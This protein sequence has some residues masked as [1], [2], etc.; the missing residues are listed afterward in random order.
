MLRGQDENNMSDGWKRQFFTIYFGQAFS[1]LGSSAVSFAII[2]WLT[3]QTESAV[4]LSISTLTTVIPGLI[5]S[6][7]AGVIVDRYSRKNIIIIADGMIALT[8]II[9]AFGFMFF[10]TPPLWFILMIL[11]LRSIGNCFHSP[12]MHAAIP[13]LVPSEKLTQVGGWIS[14]VSSLSN[15]IGPILGAFLVN[16]ISI[17]GAMGVDVAGAVIAI[18]CLLRVTIPKTPSHNLEG[19]FFQDFKQGTNAIRNNKALMA[20]LPAMVLCNLIYMPLGSLFP[21]MVRVHFIRGAWYN[22]MSEIAFA[23]GLLI[24]SLVISIWGSIKKRFLLVSLSIIVLG[25]VSAISGLLQ[26]NGF[27]IFIGCCF[28]MG[29]TGS[30]INIPL[31]A[32]VQQTTAPDM[33]GKVK[34]IIFMLMSLVMPIGLIIA[35]PV[36]DIIGIDT[37]F[38]FS[39]ICLV[40]VGILCMLRTRKY[41]K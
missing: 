41:D 3:V 28:I 24:S 15:M 6:P 21:L 37:W 18:C 36:S 1:L 33:L 8:S 7:L 40:L 34:S 38:F 32:Y 27:W 20:V 5:F 39:G 9:M 29:I 26:M 35:G 11:V 22:S 4:V 17:I 13:M 16:D 25:S 12:A 10:T 23:T 2:W 30:L 14:L 19:N 31:N